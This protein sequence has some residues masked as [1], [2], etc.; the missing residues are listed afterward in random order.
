MGQMKRMMEYSEMTDF[1]QELLDEG[2]LS[3]AAEG[4]TK[5][6]VADGHMEA[7]SEKQNEVFEEYVL[8]KYAKPCT[9]CG[10]EMPWSELSAARDNG[11]LCSWCW[12]RESKDD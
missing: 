12:N 4:I 8:N 5:K 9:S 7:L 2:V 6:V 3:G 11:G 10:T 1:L